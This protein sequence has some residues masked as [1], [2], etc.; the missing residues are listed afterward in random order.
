MG[1]LARLGVV[2]GLD[3]AEFQQGLEN[4]D[5]QL[6]RFVQRIPTVAA[7]GATAFAAMAHE[8]LKFA[9]ELS[10]TAKAN[11]MT[12][13]SILKL[14][15]ALML[16]GGEAENAGRMLSSFTNFIDKAASGNKE[17]QDSFAKMG[18]SLKE[19]GSLSNEQL[20]NK[21]SGNLAKIGDTVTRNAKGNDAFGRSMKGVDLVGFNEELQRGTRLTEDQTQSILDAGNAWDLLAKRTH[22][23]KVV[24][25]AFVGTSMLKMVEYL[26]D[27][28]NKIDQ[29]GIAFEHLGD[30]ISFVN[31]LAAALITQDVEHL[32]RTLAEY[33]KIKDDASLGKFDS[34]MGKD[35]ENSKKSQD[36]GKKR[37]I[38]A[39][40][41]AKKL[42]QMLAMAQLI[43]VEYKRHLE[44]NLSNLKSQGDMAFMTENQRKIQ[45]AVNKVSDDTSKKL[46]ELQ[47]KREE[48]SAHDGGQDVIDEID[49]QAIAIR[50]LGHE[51]EK[52]TQAEIEMQVEQQRTFEF[53]WNKAFG[54][55]VEDSKNAAT[56]G[57]QYF[58]TMAQGISS[59]IDTFVQTGKFSFQDFTASIIRNLI[60][61]EMKMQ[62]MALFRMAIGSLGIGGQYTPGSDSFVGPMPAK[63]DGG[64]V[65]GGSPYMVGERG[66]EMFIPQG[67]GTIIP[68]SRSGGGQNNQPQVVYN[69]PYIASMSAIDTQSATQFLAKNKQTIWAVNQ[70]AQRSLPVSR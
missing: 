53:G 65:G 43:S 5:K 31:N 35:W 3:S 21:V 20:L 51:Y 67:S 42:A 22:E 47:K 54:Q 57:G 14:Q 49:N 27:L 38:E 19:L 37:K 69:G 68:T 66:P 26:D 56:T 7:A 36:E 39:T 23:S 40:A 45:E 25:T 52:L 6:A 32:K 61:I 46:D 60:A 13:E 59:A 11:D 2:L 16:S 9:D 62:A 12:V 58:Q 30:T 1:M 28:P 48:A 50:L 24:F 44:F 17:A 33:K 15:N 41:E 18:V 63:A 29:V 34:G 8:A 10:D 64:F 4:A 70:S 55:Y